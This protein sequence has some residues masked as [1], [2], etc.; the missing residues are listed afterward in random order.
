M[1]T[2]EAITILR[3]S[4]S[5]IPLLRT[6]RAYGPEH[7]EF[8]QSTGLE[9]A[10][11]FGPDSGISKNFTNIAYAYHGHVLL[12]NPFNIDSVIERKHFEAY[13][14]GLDMAEGILRSAIEQL[15]KH[16]ADRI[17]TESRIM[18]GE[19]SI[20]ISHGRETP[21]LRKVERFIRALGLQPVIVVLGASEGLSVDDLVEKR[22]SESD[23][24]LILA[25]AD[26]DVDG[27]KQPRLNVVHEIGL[28]QEKFGSKVIYLKEN[29]CEFPSNVRPKVWENFT[30]DNM[31]AA[32]EKISKELR[33][34]GMI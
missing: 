22:M 30:Q 4:L 10:R 28:A 21:A 14:K 31:E 2:D 16:G 3:D 5:K 33:A 23:C 13:L 15:L 20:F 34:F 11:I 17:L 8:N 12:G 6:L 26:D 24:A 27:H 19:G 18:R 25:T 7:V 32:F 1:N 29:S 9:I